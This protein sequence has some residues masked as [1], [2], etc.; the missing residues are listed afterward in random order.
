[1]KRKLLSILLSVLMI[2]SAIPTVIIADGNTSLPFTDV[3]SNDW[4]YEAVTS[5]Y[6]RGLMK[7]ITEYTFSPNG[8]MTRAELVTLLFRLSGY[9]EPSGYTV[10]FTD[11]KEGAWYYPYLV[12]AST[13]SGIIRGYSDGTFKPNAPVSR[14]EMAAMLNRYFDLF[15]MK[16]A[17]NHQL[18]DFT[19]SDKIPSWAASDIEAMR[20]SGIFAG[21]EK[22]RCNPESYATRAEVATMVVRFVNFNSFALSINPTNTNIEYSFKDSLNEDELTSSLKM[23]TDPS[24]VAQT[25]EIRDFAAIAATVNSIG[26]GEILGKDV[27]VVFKRGDFTVERTFKVKFSRFT[28]LKPDGSATEYSYS[29][30][31]VE[32]DITAALKSFSNSGSYYDK[33]SIKDYAA[34]AERLAVIAP[35]ASETIDVTLTFERGSETEERTY[36]VN[37]KNTATLKPDGSS[38]EYSF[39]DS[40]NETELL[41]AIKSF[42]DSDN[43]YDGVSIKDFDSLSE[44]IS[45]IIGGSSD[46]LQVTA[47]FQKGS[48]SVE[49]TYSVNFK[50]TA[51]VPIVDERPNAESIGVLYADEETG[52]TISK[53]QLIADEDGASIIGESTI[54][55]HGGHENKILRTRRGIYAVYVTDVYEKEDG[56]TDASDIFNVVKL[57]KDGAKILMTGECPRAWGSCLPNIIAGEDGTIYISVLANLYEIAWLNMYKIDEITEE[58]VSEKPLQL[59]FKTRGATTHGYGYSMPIPDIANGRIYGFYNAGDIP[60]YIAWF[61]YDTKT[62]EWDTN[63]YTIQIE[64]R[65]GYICGYA[66]GNGGFSFFGQRDVYGKATDGYVGLNTYLKVDDIV[67]SRAGYV[68]DAIYFYHV[69]DATKENCSVQALYE[70]D[71]KAIYEAKSAANPAIAKVDYV[72]ASYY[73]SGGVTYKD[74]DGNIHIIYTKTEDN[75]KN[76]AIFD[77][78]GNKVFDST[79]PLSGAKRDSYTYAMAQGKS[80]KYYIIAWNTTGSSSKKY[81]NIEIMSSD[82]GRTFTTVVENMELLT[83]EGS[84]TESEPYYTKLIMTSPRNGSKSDGTVNLLLFQNASEQTANNN[85]AVNYYYMSVE[86]P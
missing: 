54:G 47:V 23:S 50:N 41:A 68:F 57:T 72:G 75:S 37:F 13:I 20:L 48:V 85:S 8:N 43:C 2:A 62:D 1:M 18:E 86:L 67:K 10:D 22:G 35:G 11:V 5:V 76:H 78:N 38:T 84:F 15:G 4:F 17:D 52:I 69:P 6:D 70:P 26:F 28:E 73:G 42:A 32:S 58:V 39:E 21:D 45:A 77:A 55:T 40:V 9:P 83:T 49:R 63:C 19:D 12:W 79:L 56:Y 51:E 24:G 53:A 34:L 82:D 44:R 29:A 65:L 80:G 46:T 16:F 61:I 59:P 66:D 71:Y 64:Y 60:G 36:S 27:T 30:A 14:A 81:A 31:A 3:D 33:V 25:A 74:L 7:G